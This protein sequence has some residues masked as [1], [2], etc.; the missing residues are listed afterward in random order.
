MFVLSFTFEGHTTSPKQVFQKNFRQVARSCLLV[1][2]QSRAVNPQDITKISER[3]NVYHTT[4]STQPSPIEELVQ[5]AA[6]GL[7]L[8]VFEGFY[9]LTRF[10]PYPKAEISI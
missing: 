9:S 10:T 1:H 2:C 3:H 5:R 8:L 6:I 4:L 7:H